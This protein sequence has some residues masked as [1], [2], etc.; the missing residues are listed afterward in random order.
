MNWTQVG[1]PGILGEVGTLSMT[2]ERTLYTV[3]GDESI[4]KLP[5]WERRH[6]QLVNDT[7]LRPRHWRRYTYS[8]NKTGHFI[9]FRPMSCLLPLTVVRLGN[10]WS[11]LVQNGMLEN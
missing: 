1:E 6:W 3:I 7:F 5:A 4:Y 9:L 2:S 8:L 11:V 10:H